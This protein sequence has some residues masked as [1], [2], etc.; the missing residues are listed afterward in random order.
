LMDDIPPTLP[1]ASQGRYRNLGEAHGKLLANLTE[2]LRAGLRGESLWFCPTVYCDAFSEGGIDA[3]PYLRTLADTAPVGMPI[4]WTGASIV[5]REIKPS[6]LRPLQRLFPGRVVLWDNLY[7]HDYC[8]WKLFLGPYAGRPQ[9]LKPLLKGIMLN[10]TGLLETDLAYLDQLQA[11]TEGKPGSTAWRASLIRA[12]APQDMLKLT[13]YLNL[14]QEPWKPAL[15]APKVIA[16]ARAR[17]KPLI[18]NWKSPLQREW[19]PYLF[20]LDAD[21]RVAE[22]GR[23]QRTAGKMNSQGLD[24]EWL[25]KRY[26]P[27]LAQQ[28]IEKMEPKKTSRRTQE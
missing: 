26:T 16:A 23:P 4:F 11:W 9:S 2:D 25:R 17:L 3:D 18:W 24:P 28:L 15:Y 7:A 22:G 20:M 21:L 5:P 14:P 8:P 1:P 6:H 19:Y 10:P 12:G 13:A 27:V